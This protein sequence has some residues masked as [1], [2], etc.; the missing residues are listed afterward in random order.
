[1]VGRPLLARLMS[2]VPVVVVGVLAEDRSKVPH[3]QIVW[4]ESTIALS[5]SPDQTHCTSSGTPQ[6]GKTYVLSK[7]WGRGTVPALSTLRDA[8]A[9]AGVSFQAEE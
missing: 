4:A 2:L 7:M 9:E 1:M 3:A 5:R 8:F 6:D